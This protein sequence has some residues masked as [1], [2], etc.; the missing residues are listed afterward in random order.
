MAQISILFLFIFV[1]SSY[2]NKNL[3]NFD[4]FKLE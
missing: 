2:F 3:K 1:V 4:L